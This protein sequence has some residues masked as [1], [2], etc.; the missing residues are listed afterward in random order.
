MIFNTLANANPIHDDCDTEVKQ[1]YTK[2]YQRLRDVNGGLANVNYNENQ[3]TLNVNNIFS[4]QASYQIEEDLK[5]RPL[6]EMIPEEKPKGPA[7]SSVMEQENVRT[8]RKT[9]DIEIGTAIIAKNYS[10]SI[11]KT[12]ISVDVNFITFPIV[13]LSRP[14]ATIQSPSPIKA[15]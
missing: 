8:S 2:K 1:I 11:M 9:S 12:L 6:Q 3:N 10:G 7:P 13:S 5:K 4:R 14:L 15:S